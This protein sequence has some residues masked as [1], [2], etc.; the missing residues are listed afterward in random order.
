MSRSQLS[1]EIAALDLE[2]TARRTRLLVSGRE[3]VERLRAVP[4]RTLL[5]GG[6]VAGLASGLVVSRSGPRFQLFCMQGIRLWRMT[7]L[8]LPLLLRAEEPGADPAL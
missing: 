1:A 5:L 8:F 3:R 6:A 7:G 2:L 4:P